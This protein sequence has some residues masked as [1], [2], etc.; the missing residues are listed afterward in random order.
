MGPLV[1]WGALALANPSSDAPLALSVEQKDLT[2]E[3]VSDRPS[4]ALGT[5]VIFREMGFGP[6]IS[7][8][9]R[10]SETPLQVRPRVSAGYLKAKTPGLRDAIVAGE[11]GVEVTHSTLSWRRVSLAG[12]LSLMPELWTAPGG[13]EFHF[14]GNG[15]IMAILD[16]NKVHLTLSLG[17]DQSAVGV[18]FW[19]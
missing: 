11:F 17:V 3:M 10:W 19:F 6:A 15:G 1:L 4:F 12:F 8:T 5:D 9:T 18:R 13:N 7:F 2:L 14:H 16:L